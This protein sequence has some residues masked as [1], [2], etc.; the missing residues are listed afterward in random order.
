MLFATSLKAT[1]TTVLLI[2]MINVSPKMRGKKK[3][4]LLKLHLDLMT[5]L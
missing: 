1:V 4:E 2:V 3:I 5:V